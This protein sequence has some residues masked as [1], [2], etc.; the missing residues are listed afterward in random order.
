MSAS[1]VKLRDRNERNHE[2]VVGSR[3]ESFDG[4]E[5]DNILGKTVPHL[6]V[7]VNEKMEVGIK[8]RLGQ[9][10]E[11]KVTASGVLHSTLGDRSWVEK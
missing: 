8:L 7:V 5:R 6:R 9:G 11:D 1:M 3:L 10:E 2:A 4:R